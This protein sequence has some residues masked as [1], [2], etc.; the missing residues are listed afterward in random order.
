MPFF[1]SVGSPLELPKIEEP[2]TEQ[3]NEYHKKFTDHLVELFE[4]QKHNYLKNADTIFLELD[5]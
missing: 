1:V 5:G 2:T 4:M 3:I